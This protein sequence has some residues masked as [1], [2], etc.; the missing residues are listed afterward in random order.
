[1]HLVYK[2]YVFEYKDCISVYKIASR[3][4]INQH[5]IADQLICNYFDAL[6]AYIDEHVLSDCN[7][8]CRRCIMY[9]FAYRT[10]LGSR[11]NRELFYHK[12]QMQLWETNK[13]ETIMGIYRDIA[14]CF[15]RPFNER[16]IR[17]SAFL[18]FGA[19]HRLYEEFCRPGSNITIDDVCYYAIHT[20][21]QLS[22]LDQTI[23]EANIADAFEFAN[24]HTPPVIS[25]FHTPTESPTTTYEEFVD[26]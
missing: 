11:Q 19:R 26:K 14:K 4:A 5:L 25:P 24:A 15:H 21:G 20:V 12:A 9:I 1:M 16:D 7:I 22:Y 3:S 18:D 6:R 13:L 17:F 8:Y 23:V 10:I 2:T